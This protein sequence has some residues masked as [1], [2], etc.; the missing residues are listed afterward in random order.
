MCTCA[1]VST[2]S[3]SLYRVFLVFDITNFLWCRNLREAVARNLMHVACGNITALMIS[4]P[5][6]ACVFACKWAKKWPHFRV[7]VEI[8][9]RIKKIELLF[10]LEFAVQAISWKGDMSDWFG[11]VIIN[12]RCIFTKIR[13]KFHRKGFASFCLEKSILHKKVNLYNYT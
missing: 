2:C 12:G 3:R 13:N 11:S 7:D 9:F 6:I 8:W 10:E 4:T 5:A 1:Y